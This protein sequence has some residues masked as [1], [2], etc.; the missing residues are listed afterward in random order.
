MEGIRMCEARKPERGWKYL[1]IK[2]KSDIVTSWIQ[3][4]AIFIGVVT[5]VTNIYTQISEGKRFVIELAGQFES[6]AEKHHG[7]ILELSQYALV[8]NTI[9]EQE[10]EKREISIA[11]K[12]DIS[13]IQV[14]NFLQRVASLSEY[15]VSDDEMTKKMFCNHVR[16][17]YGSQTYV[18]KQVR[19]TAG[20]GASKAFEELKNLST[21]CST[22]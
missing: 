17:I 13:H 8:K 6:L 22:E 14:L 10:R 19:S 4:I 21:E 7:Y 2:D 11:Q 15:G 12:H 18:I 5:F 3:L 9:N 20:L 1:T 16:F